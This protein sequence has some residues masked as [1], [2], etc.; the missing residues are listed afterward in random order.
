[1]YHGQILISFQL[2]A[3][4]KEDDNIFVEFKGEKVMDLKINQYAF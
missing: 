1:M 3:K 2:N 4:P